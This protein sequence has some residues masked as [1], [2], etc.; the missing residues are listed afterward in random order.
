MGASIVGNVKIKLETSAG[1]F[2]S[3]SLCLCC[4]CTL[5][6]LGCAR[7]TFRT[8][9]HGSS[10]APSLIPAPSP[11]CSSSRSRNT[12]RSA[13]PSNGCI[14]PRC[15]STATGSYCTSAAPA[16]PYPRSRRPSNHSRTTTN[17]Y[18]ATISTILLTS[19]C[20]SI[21]I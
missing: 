12:Y 17:N 3:S 11:P 4:L 8:H 5:S 1:A 13:S 9:L 7:I 19:S 15:S 2:F 21:A 10:R 6:A 16:L 20:T 14:F 18:S